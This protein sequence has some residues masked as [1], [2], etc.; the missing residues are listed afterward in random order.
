MKKIIFSLVIVTSLTTVSCKKNYNCT[1]V[2][3]LG[4]GGPNT[5]STTVINNTKSKAQKACTGLESSIAVGSETVT[6][7]I[8]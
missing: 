8:Q 7:S 5:N 6:C 4:G 2:A 1:C 3:E